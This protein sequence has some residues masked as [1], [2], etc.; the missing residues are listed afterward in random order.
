MEHKYLKN[1]LAIMVFFISIKSFG[2]RNAF[3]EKFQ[4]YPGCSG[5]AETT[6]AE[7]IGIFHEEV[8]VEKIKGFCADKGETIKIEEI[9]EMIG[10]HP[11]TGSCIV[12]DS[13]HYASPK[14]GNFGTFDGYSGPVMV[15]KMFRNE[16][17]QEYKNIIYCWNSC[18]P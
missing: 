2:G 9:K 16:P 15:L 7:S 4:E 10:S 3:C 11:N 12:L 1:I 14:E 17:T 5:H 13:L 18:H 8:D 6:G